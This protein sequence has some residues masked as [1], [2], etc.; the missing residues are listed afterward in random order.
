MKI[1]VGNEL[2]FRT[3]QVVPDPVTRMEIQG[4]SMKAGQKNVKFVVESVDEANAKILELKKE[5]IGDL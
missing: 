1:S 2:F 5:L 4:S 3:V